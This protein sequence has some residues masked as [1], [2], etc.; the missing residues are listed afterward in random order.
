MVIAI[1]PKRHRKSVL[2][3]GALRKWFPAI[4][5]K[6]AEDYTIITFSRASFELFAMDPVN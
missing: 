3:K 1:Q 4:V 6:H 2:S 5:S